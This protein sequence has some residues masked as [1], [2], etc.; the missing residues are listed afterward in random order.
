MNLILVR[1]AKAEDRLNWKGPDSSRPLTEKGI[2]HFRQMMDKFSPR[3]PKPDMI[4]SS[5]FLRAKQT[6]ELLS[7]I[8]DN[9]EI[10]LS[11][12]LECMR[13][14]EEKM[15]LIQ[16][17]QKHGLNTVYFV[18]H[19]PDLGRLASA[20]LTKSET[21][22]FHLKKG[23]MISIDNPN[24]NPTLLWHIHRKLISP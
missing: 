10:I 20:I 13:P 18:G 3:I 12:A 1:H 19:E 2:K 8:W 11:E 16:E 4:V 22:F 15:H 14:L 7:S 21:S 6:A 17:V 23:G 24:F 9:Q 5:S